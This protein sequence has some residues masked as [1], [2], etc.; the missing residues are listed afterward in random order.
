MSLDNN[1]ESTENFISDESIKKIIEQ[2]TGLSKNTVREKIFVP[3]KKLLYFSCF[4][5]VHNY[6]TF[7]LTMP[8]EYS[9]SD[10]FLML[11]KHW[12]NYLHSQ[13]Y[14]TI[15]FPKK[16]DICPPG[17]NA[18]Q[19]LSTIEL[20]SLTDYQITTFEWAIPSSFI[21]LFC[22]VTISLME[23][24]NS[25]SDNCY[26]NASAFFDK[27]SSYIDKDQ[28][29]T[30]HSQYTALCTYVFCKNY[31]LKTTAFY[32]TTDF[33]HASARQKNLLQYAIRTL[34][35]CVHMTFGTAYMTTIS[36]YTSTILNAYIEKLNTG[37]SE[38]A[39][40]SLL[41]PHQIQIPYFEFELNFIDE[42]FSSIE[43][44][45]STYTE[46]LKGFFSPEQFKNNDYCLSKD[47]LEQI[48]SL[49]K[50]EIIPEIHAKME[51][52]NAKLTDSYRYLFDS[53]TLD[54]PIDRNALYPH[55]SFCSN[56]LKTYS[57]KLEAAFN[58]FITDI[59]KHNK[60][61]FKLSE[62]VS[63]FHTL[64]TKINDANVT[65]NASKDNFSKLPPIAHLNK[66]GLLNEYAYWHYPIFSD[67]IH[68]FLENLLIDLNLLENLE[69]VFSDQSLSRIRSNGCCT[70]IDLALI[71]KVVA[72]YS[73][74]NN[75][76]QL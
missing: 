49:I 76:L 5:N 53:A 41:Y 56:Y 54:S 72:D 71:L 3:L 4:F 14:L 43:A 34:T 65:Y 55:Q 22:Y 67:K 8:K 46:K 32:E 47:K 73:Y 28:N 61:R 21:N 35:F 2:I 38:D 31:L 17:S 20:C 29:A 26:F 23:A 45:T 59:N 75:R 64:N 48:K 30:L 62:E 15:S 44:I 40:F 36:E 6:T 12:C 51:E 7:K 68:D 13:K 37:L 42:A 11:L 58:H 60:A 33:I 9:V 63:I 74:Q 25:I 27:L 18:L 19:V 66:N 50:T 24:Y 10:E 39:N 16:T 69:L 57:N 70:I 52:Y 1:T